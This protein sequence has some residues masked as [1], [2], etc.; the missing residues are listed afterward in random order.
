MPS[1]V[2]HRV[3]PHSL[4]P[5]KRTRVVRAGDSCDGR[6]DPQLLVVAT[7][8]GFLGGNSPT[9]QHR[10]VEVQGNVAHHQPPLQTLV[11]SRLAHRSLKLW[12]EPGHS[13]GYGSNLHFPRGGPCVSTSFSKKPI[14]SPSKV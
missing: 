2:D 5:S 3:D 7:A 1:A 6:P 12:D 10:H 13:I 9:S 14:V 4:G 11:A 8:R